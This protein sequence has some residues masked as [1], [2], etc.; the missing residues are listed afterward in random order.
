MDI[1]VQA[2][3]PRQSWV[4]AR[5]EIGGE[6]GGEDDADELVG[7]GRQEELVDMKWKSG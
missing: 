1:P 5:E 4:D 6:E 3:S 2:R 7:Q